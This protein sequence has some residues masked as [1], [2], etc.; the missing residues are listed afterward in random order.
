MS[1]DLY[2]QLN[3]DPSGPALDLE[4]PLEVVIG[5]IPLMSVVQQYPP[6]PPVGFDENAL[7]PTAPPA[8]M[9]ASAPPP[10]MRELL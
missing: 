9:G 4:I 2:L 7:W 8:A 3:V 6:S 10:N 1:H 5:T